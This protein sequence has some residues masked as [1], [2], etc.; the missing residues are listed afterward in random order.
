MGIS[1]ADIKR[2]QQQANAPEKKK[3][4]QRY[5]EAAAKNNAAR[6]ANMPVCTNCGFQ[7]KPKLY[8]KGN[9]L[10]EIFLW[11]IFLL[12]GIIYSI[13]RHASRYK[14]CPE[15]GAANMIPATSPM[16]KKILEQ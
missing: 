5:R 6:A 1:G 8:T 7:G 2:Q 10:L 16:T 13:W 3:F 11:L 9:L 4:T 15:C 14:G 12:P